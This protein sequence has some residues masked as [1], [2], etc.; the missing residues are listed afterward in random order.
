MM[1]LHCDRCDGLV[2]PFR[3]WIEDNESKLGQ[4]GRPVVGAGTNPVWHISFLNDKKF[5]RAC[6]IIV[7]ETYAKLLKAEA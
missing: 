2:E 6:M 7:L 3:T 5:C 4:E 1:R